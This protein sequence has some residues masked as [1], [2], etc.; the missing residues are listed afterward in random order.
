MTEGPP[1][2]TGDGGS[3][4]GDGCSSYVATTTASRN[5]NLRNRLCSYRGSGNPEL[6]QAATSSKQTMVSNEYP[7]G[8]HFQ[9]CRA[10]DSS[11]YSD[12]SG[13]NNCCP[14]RLQ[15]K[16]SLSVVLPRPMDRPPFSP[17]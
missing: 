17:H 15:C 1:Q 5:L 14:H 12:H 16:R 7:Q 10:R 6:A 8:S 3:P 13:K 2:D 4:S 9:R 11:T